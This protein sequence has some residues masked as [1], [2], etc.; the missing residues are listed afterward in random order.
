MRQSGRL[1]SGYV[2]HRARRRSRPRAPFAKRRQR[3]IR[4]HFGRRLKRRL[5]LH[6][7]VVERAG[8]LLMT[9]VN[10]R[11]GKA[12]TFGI[13]D[14]T[15][16]F[17][18]PGNPA[19]AYMASSSSFARACSKCRAAPRSSTPRLSQSLPATRK[20]RIPADSSCAPRF[21]MRIGRAS[22]NAREEPE[23]WSFRPY[24]ENELHGRFARRGTRRHAGD[25]IAA[26]FGCR[27]RN[28]YLIPRSP[29][30][31]PL[32]D[33]VGPT[34]DDPSS[35]ETTSSPLTQKSQADITDSPIMLPSARRR[36]PWQHKA[37]SIR[38]TIRPS[39]ERQSHDS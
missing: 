2:R 4:G 21:P 17:G 8:E 7:P 38:L 5:R 39:Q 6:Q 29:D 18:L 30:N 27:R 28:R 9:T 3:M 14:G 11:P 33:V 24:P 31:Q 13:V 34:R 10:M 35:D 20:R 32:D 25:E 23:L 36:P 37:R 1:R 19:A 12:Q 26:C 22:R 15:P 16:V